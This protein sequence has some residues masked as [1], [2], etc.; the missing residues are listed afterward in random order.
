MFLPAKTIVASGPV[1]IENGKVLLNQE[2]KPY[3]SSLFMFP[4]GMVENF[5]LPL[6]ETCHREVK[7]EMGIDVKIIRP[8]PTMIVKRPDTEDQYAILVHFLAERIG[9]INPGPETIAWDW[10]DINNLPD[11][12]AP[13]VYEIIKGLRGWASPRE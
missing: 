12:C 4:G 5:D 8:L 13:N 10:F 1:I 9:E 7:E 3:G 6:E 11:N 2:K